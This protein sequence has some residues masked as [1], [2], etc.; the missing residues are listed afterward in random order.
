MTRQH[1]A[2]LKVLSTPQKIAID[3]VRLEV[4]HDGDEPSVMDDLHVISEAI[5]KLSVYALILRIGL[6]YC[7][8][9]DRI[10]RA[11]RR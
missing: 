8:H 9:E 3:N 10:S 5:A 2:C 4:E 6:R 1:D 7:K 11:S